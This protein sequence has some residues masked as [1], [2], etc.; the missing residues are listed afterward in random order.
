[1]T[2]DADQTVSFIMEL[3][4]ARSQCHDS[5]ADEMQTFLSFVIPALRAVYAFERSPVLTQFMNNMASEVVISLNEAFTD[6][7]HCIQSRSRENVESGR[8]VI[9]SQDEMAGPRK[10]MAISEGKKTPETIT[11]AIKTGARTYVES[12]VQALKVSY[13]STATYGIAGSTSCVK[14]F[15][16]STQ[17]LDWC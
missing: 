9:R 16:C 13:N 5:C 4:R 1:M 15:F 7:L 8:T 2:Q 6:A 17:I 11:R 14:L 3:I 10:I 12:V